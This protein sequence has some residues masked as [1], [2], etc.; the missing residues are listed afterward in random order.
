[1]LAILVFS[2]LY[3]LPTFYTKVPGRGCFDTCLQRM[4]YRLVKTDLRHNR[5]Y[6]V[7]YKS[8]LT[9]LISFIVPFATLLTL[10][11]KIMCT[12][13]AIAKQKLTGRCTVKGES[14][15]KNLQNKVGSYERR[16]IFVLSD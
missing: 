16:M 1:M 15:A 14:K 2:I 8:N 9:L 6:I 3:I 5:F 7:I 12:M 10:N 13:R 11:A 4:V